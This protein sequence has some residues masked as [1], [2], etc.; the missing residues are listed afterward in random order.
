MTLSVDQLLSKAKSCARKG[1]VQT[2][3]QIYKS[4]LQRFPKN[5]R[6]LK[7][8]QALQGQQPAGNQPPQNQIN[9][10]ISLLQQGQLQQV[11]QHATPMTRQFPNTTALHDFL[12]MAHMGLQNYNQSL[13]NFR[14]VLHLQPNYPE[15][16]NN[17]GAALKAKG[18]LDK[19][20]QSYQKAL[21]LKPDYAEAYSNLGQIN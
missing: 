9:A 19:A 4:V 17:L 3:A 12:G 11:V 18:Q 16:H 6:A 7:S 2:A 5:K 20:I 21:K 8:L 13:E 10:L 1:D 14:K 15:A